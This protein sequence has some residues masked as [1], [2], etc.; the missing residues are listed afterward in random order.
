MSPQIK[1]SD[2]FCYE[3]VAPIDNYEP[4]INMSLRKKDH[5]HILEHIAYIVD[6]LAV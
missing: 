2:K 1:F 6:A 5:I 4:G 3:L